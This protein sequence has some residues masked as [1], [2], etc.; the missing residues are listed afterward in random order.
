MYRPLTNNEKILLDKYCTCEKVR[1][2]P[3]FSIIY[4]CDYELCQLTTFA[5][6]GTTLILDE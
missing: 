2:S 4:S 5:V 3:N 6:N 1:Y